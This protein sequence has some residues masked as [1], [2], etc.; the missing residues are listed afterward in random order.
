MTCSIWASFLSCYFW[1][2]ARTVRLQLSSCGCALVQHGSCSPYVPWCE[3]HMWAYGLGPF[4]LIPAAIEF[5]VLVSADCLAVLL[6]T[7]GHAKLWN[8]CSILEGRF[9]NNAWRSSACAPLDVT[10][11]KLSE[12]YTSSSQNITMWEIH[13]QGHAGR[14][15]CKHIY[16]LFLFFVTYPFVT[17]FICLPKNNPLWSCCSHLSRKLQVV[18]CTVREY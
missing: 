13:T 2:F 11:W 15:H 3:W 12:C 16:L 10:H 6:Y 5:A 14:S 7:L 4:F 17:L 9:N 8:I 1:T 18:K